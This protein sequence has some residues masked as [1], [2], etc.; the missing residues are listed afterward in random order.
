[1]SRLKVLVVVVEFS[2]LTSMENDFVPSD[3]VVEY[4]SLLLLL[5]MMFVVVSTLSGL[6]K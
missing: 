1:M 6:F 2:R 3:P 4:W 5:Q